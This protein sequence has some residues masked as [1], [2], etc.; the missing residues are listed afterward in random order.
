MM[1]GPKTTTKLCNDQKDPDNKKSSRCILPKGHEG[2]PH[3]SIGQ[4]G[5][6]VEWPQR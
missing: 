2:T 1:H 6:R 4:D 5:V 3:E